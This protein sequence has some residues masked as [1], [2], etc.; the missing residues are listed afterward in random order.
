MAIKKVLLIAAVMFLSVA[1]K[2]ENISSFDFDSMDNGRITDGMITDDYTQGLNI[3]LYDKKCTYTVTNGC[4]GKPGCDKVL[5]VSSSE[6]S[7]NITFFSWNM[8][9]DKS[10]QPNVGNAEGENCV[11]GFEFAKKS[12]SPFRVVAVYTSG[13]DNC[14]SEYGTDLMNVMANGSLE[15]LGENISEYKIQDNRWYSVCYIIKPIKEKCGCCAADIYIN[16]VNVK[17][18]DKVML[19]PGLGA[20]VKYMTRLGFSSGRGQQPW[21]SGF[22]Y[23]C[24]NVFSENNTGSY[25]MP[26]F[27]FTDDE[28]KKNAMSTAVF[29]KNTIVSDIVSQKNVKIC[30]VNADGSEAYGCECVQGKILKFIPD[31]NDVPIYEPI[32]IKKSSVSAQSMVLQKE[33]GETDFSDMTPGKRIYAVSGIENTSGMSI[34]AAVILVLYRNGVPE[35]VSISTA[36]V[37]NN[38]KLYSLSAETEIPYDS[39][40]CCIK[41]FAMDINTLYPICK[42][43]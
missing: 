24:D 7:D 40:N 38:A 13:E 32:T 6:K 36:E 34:K 33:T 18:L 14:Y 25:K 31:N 5:D 19:V 17:S 9:A 2:A 4:F 26:E 27:C 42:F 39:E 12:D 3:T 35:K 23:K 43:P 16:G 37:E 1:A 10:V 30:V 21:Q 11:V 15:I 41:G 29:G 28:G 20:N 8:Q 22:G